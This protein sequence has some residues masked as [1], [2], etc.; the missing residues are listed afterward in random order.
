MIREHLATSS[1]ELLKYRFIRNYYVIRQDKPENIYDCHMTGHDG[2]DWLN[3][4]QQSA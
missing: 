1:D 2:L 3:K 4:H